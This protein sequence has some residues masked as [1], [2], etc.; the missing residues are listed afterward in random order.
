MLDLQVDDESI[1]VTKNNPE[2]I[3]KRNLNDFSIICNNVLPDISNP[4]LE[5]LCLAFRDNV[6]VYHVERL[7]VGNNI[8]A[9]ITKGGISDYCI[10]TLEPNQE[11]NS[12]NLPF[13]VAYDSNGG[14]WVIDH[15]ASGDAYFNK[16][17]ENFN[18]IPSSTFES[19][20][21]Y[22]GFTFG[23]DGKPVAVYFEYIYELQKP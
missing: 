5:N 23:E 15:R 21:R 3:V 9:G 11:R 14:L 17:D 12:M 7:G 20:H 10:V 18:V 4:S 13:D 19:E 16:V 1:W 6:K 22:K 8:R 2:R